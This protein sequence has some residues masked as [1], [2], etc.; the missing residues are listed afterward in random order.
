MRRI[1]TVF[2]FVLLAIVAP[3]GHEIPN[4]VTIYTF[5]KPEGKR[6]LFLVR[7][8]MRALRD[9]EVPRREGTFQ[10]YV[11]LERADRALHDAATQWIAD[12]VKL[13]EEGQQ[14]PYP[15]VS[16][17]RATLHCLLYTS[18]SPRDTRESRVAAWAG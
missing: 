10:G 9:I 8:P 6:L 5:L 1:L 14:L 13:Y 16:G 17:V 11:D 15:E 3:Q 7:A 4:E 12:F 2:V 18:P